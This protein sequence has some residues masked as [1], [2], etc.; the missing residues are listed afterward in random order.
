MH[1]CMQT[2]IMHTRAHGR[3]M[4]IYIEV[5]LFSP[6]LL[7]SLPSSLLFSPLVLSSPLSSVAPPFP[8]SLHTWHLVHLHPAPCR[9]TRIPL[10]SSRL[11]LPPPLG[12]RPCATKD[13]RASVQLFI[14]LLFYDLFIYLY[15]IFIFYF[16]WGDGLLRQWFCSFRL[17][18]R[19]FCCDSCYCYH[20]FSYIQFLLSLCLVLRILFLSNVRIFCSNF[21]CFF[22]SYFPVNLLFSV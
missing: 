17:K 9:D 18:F 2:C 12:R 8:G 1:A 6:L 19:Y 10:L 21:C 11:A 14:Y 22:L 15:F 13:A 5:F 7:S 20:F 16:F 3:Y 4:Y